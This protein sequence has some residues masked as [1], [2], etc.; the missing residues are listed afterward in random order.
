MNDILLY[1]VSTPIGNMEDITI[2]ALKVLEQVDFILCEDTRRSIKLLNHFNIKNKLISYHKFNEQAISEKIIRRLYDGEKAALISDAG[3]PLLSD[4]GSIL[5]NKLI[6]NNIAFTVIPGAN[7]LLPA[8]IFSGYNINEFTFFGFLPKKSSLRN[9]SLMKISKTD[10]TCVVYA[11]AH[12]IKT[13]LKEISEIM[14]HRKLA[15]SKEL[16]KIYETTYR[17][18][19]SEIYSLLEDPPK[20]EYVLVFSD[21]QHEA[22]E[23][24]E[25][26]LDELKQMYE[27]LLDKLIKPNDALK[28][29]A[30]KTHIPRN[31]LYQ[32]LRK[33]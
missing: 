22:P 2:R 1:V 32:K 15:L 12:E 33:H 11:A 16:T 30:E 8:L 4:P 27:E 5:I 25:Y 23:N 9:I 29:L 7:A 28:Q 6:D 14:P 3:T 17:G 26:D 31:E 10:K 21:T 24:I 20:G 13:L 18:T 19:S